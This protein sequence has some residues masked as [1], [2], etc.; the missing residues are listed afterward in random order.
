MAR[1]SAEARAPQMEGEELPEGSRVEAPGALKREVTKIGHEVGSIEHAKGIDGTDREEIRFGASESGTQSYEVSA[2]KS[3]DGEVRL[4]AVSPL[5]V[6]AH[7][8][9]AKSFEQLYSNFDAMAQATLQTMPGLT[10]DARAQAMKAIAELNPLDLVGSAVK[11]QKNPN[12]ALA[13]LLRAKL[14][15][16]PEV[17]TASEKSLLQLESM[18]RQAT[19]AARIAEK[20]GDEKAFH[21]AQADIY[22]SEK[23]ILALQERLNPNASPAEKQ[24]QVDRI[25]GFVQILPEP[26]YEQGVDAVQ[27][28]LKELEALMSKADKANDQLA[29]QTAR[30]EYDRHR[31][32]MPT[33]ERVQK[34][35][36]LESDAQKAMDEAVA[37]QLLERGKARARTRA[38]KSYWNK[39]A[40]DATFTLGQVTE[41]LRTLEKSA[42]GGKNVD[43]EYAKA[44]A[45]RKEL[46][47]YLEQVKGQIET[48][49]QEN[50]HLKEA[51]LDINLEPDLKVVGAKTEIYMNLATMSRENPDLVATYVA[52]ALKSKNT[53]PA[54]LGILKEFKADLEAGRLNAPEAKPE[55]ADEDENLLD[56]RFGAN[57]DD[58]EDVGFS[59]PAAMEKTRQDKPKGVPQED[60]DDRFWQERS[61]GKKA[62]E[63]AGIKWTAEDADKLAREAQA[64]VLESRAKGVSMED[65]DAAYW[66]SQR[67]R[68]VETNGNVVGARTEATD[69]S[70]RRAEMP[71]VTPD[72]LGGKKNAKEGMPGFGEWVADENAKQRKNIEVRAAM[73][74]MLPDEEPAETSNQAESSAGRNILSSDIF[75]QEMTRNTEFAQQIDAIASETSTIDLA[76]EI[77]DQAYTAETIAFNK[78]IFNGL[79]AENRLSNGLPA[80]WEEVANP[81]IGFFSRITGGKNRTRKALLDKINNLQ[82]QFVTTGKEGAR[83]V[84][85]AADI[86]R[87]RTEQAYQDKGPKGLA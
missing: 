54:T 47:A 15:A 19:E 72:M 23:Q 56:S 41:A 39:V 87:T 1:K 31:A 65:H 70:Q 84:S 37:K 62:A 7:D 46:E 60:I 6:A 17:K 48:L 5:E 83:Q 11:S 40:D 13:G 86:A 69:P 42:Q 18:R 71:V 55:A 43:A 21:D 30:N 27:A 79:S 81:K 57:D 33:L 85:S 22:A 75:S 38:K 3:A 4:R 14:E 68:G 77:G 53:S 26:V 59:E 20:S 64:R 82:G 24:T 50:D 52:S 10:E 61:A 44:D 67:S 63:E 80:T 76:R 73:A 36:T 28:R 66:R 58:E 78:A 34:L 8:E 29:W 12:E 49:Q 25:E 32:I 2:R 74:G 45:A 16:H 51:G 9:A 35:Q